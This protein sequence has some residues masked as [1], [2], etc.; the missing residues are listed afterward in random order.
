MS[1]KEKYK[2]KGKSIS[3]FSLFE[4]LTRQ[5]SSVEKNFQRVQFFCLFAER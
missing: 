4:I 1:D 2:G 5:D 3:L